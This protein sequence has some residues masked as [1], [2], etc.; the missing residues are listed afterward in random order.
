MLTVQDPAL[1][2]APPSPVTIVS[3][4]ANACS[5]ATITLTA[6]NIP[7]SLS[8]F[9]FQWQSRTGTNN[10]AD[11][12]TGG[13]SQSYTVTQTEPTDYVVIVNCQYG[14]TP[15]KSNI[16][17]I[18]Q[19]DFL[20]CYGNCASTHAP[21]CD[22]GGGTITN[23][24][25]RTLNSSSA[26][27][28]TGAPYLTVFPASGTTT[29]SL[30]MGSTYPLTVSNTANPTAN[31]GYY[32]GV[33]IDYNHSATFDASEFI[34]N[35]YATTS[36]T[37]TTTTISIAVP[38]PSSTVL[39]GPT[40]MRIVSDNAASTFYGTFAATDGCATGR[41]G[42]ET[43]DYI[44]TLSATPLPV[45]LLSFT[46][47]AD[48][49][50]AVRLAWATASEQNSSY[51]EVERSTDGQRF[52][53]IGRVSAQGNASSL[54]SYTFRDTKSSESSTRYYRL[55]QVDLDGS[56]EYSLVRTVQLSTATTLM[57]APNP[58]HSAVTVTGTAAGAKV[59]VFDAVGR[60]VIATT[61]DAAGTAQLA[62][63]TKLASGIYVVRSGRLVSRLAVE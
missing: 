25:L 58:A 56:A 24:S 6:N 49:S 39:S 1:C 53:S 18:G 8:G 47:E 13:T 30:A 38:V 26:C 29:T 28:P 60:L 15:E 22:T 57:L 9:T 51:F 23:V 33:W 63:P 11:V 21:G 35:T 43:E 34:P 14:G 50:S 62:L 5:N 42:G 55:R 37:Q 46:A 17:S 48:G 32:Y 54:S 44:V 41:I 36:T 52:E 31:G 7:S 45:K 3:S 16:L 19:N 40:R 27:A 2:A 10:F 61:A 4:Q 20:D 12:P 59:E